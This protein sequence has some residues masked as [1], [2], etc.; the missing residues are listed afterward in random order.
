MKQFLMTL[1]LLGLGA[2]APADW[3]GPEGKD[4]DRYA[5]RSLEKVLAANPL[6]E[7]ESFKVTA[8]YE[9]PRSRHVLVQVRDREPAHVH[10]DSDITVWLLQGQGVMHVGGKEHPVKAGDVI[11]IPRDVVHYYVNQG[12]EIGAALVVYS[13]APGPDDRVLIR[14]LWP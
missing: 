6:G 7:N 9:N 3:L 11:H 2:A 12:P 5:P 4:A 8:L 10:T 13:P 14:K 1:T